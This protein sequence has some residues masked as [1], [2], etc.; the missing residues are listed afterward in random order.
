MVSVVAAA[1]AA[2]TRNKSNQAKKIYSFV[3]LTAADYESLP[4]LELIDKR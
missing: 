3:F 1:A 4:K 2:L